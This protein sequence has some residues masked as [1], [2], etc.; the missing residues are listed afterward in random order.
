MI[1]LIYGKNEI[2][3]L[4]IN[5]LMSGQTDSFDVNDY[6]YFFSFEFCKE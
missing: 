1:A 2:H 5:D 3:V 4:D 6:V